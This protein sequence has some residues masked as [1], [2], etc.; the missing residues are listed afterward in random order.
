MLQLKRNGDA[1]R[2]PSG[3]AGL[4]E[5]RL[6]PSLAA[7]PPAWTP[8]PRWA[9]GWPAPCA[10]LA[11]RAA[12][13]AGRGGLR[14]EFLVIGYVA[15]VRPDGPALPRFDVRP[16]DRPALAFAVERPPVGRVVLGM[17]AVA[18]ADVVPEIGQDRALA[19]HRRPAP[20]AVILE[21]AVDIIRIAH[22]GADGVELG[23][24]QIV[25]EDP[26]L[27]VVVGQGRAA[28][29]ADVKS[30]LVGRIE[31]HRVEVGMQSADLA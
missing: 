1:P 17:E 2:P 26:A 20:G 13:A 5:L 25:E 19:I 15:L 30:I 11:A 9:G 7:L 29:L 24:A 12:W 21:T 8:W 23:E 3:P 14:E 4:A 27:A 16:L 22:V 31:P 28:V 10:G 18:A 6:S